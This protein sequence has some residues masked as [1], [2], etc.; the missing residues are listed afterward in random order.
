MSIGGWRLAA[1]GLGTAAMMAGTAG[2]AQGAVRIEKHLALAPG[3][4]LS[5]STEVGSVVVRGDA[6]SGAAV[7]VTSDR[8]DLEQEYE[9]T[10]AATPG[11]AQVIIKRRHP[12]WSWFGGWQHWRGRVEIAVDVPRATAVSV[13]ASGGRVEAS[14]LEGDTELSSSGGAVAAHEL[15]GKLVAHSSGGAV[16]VRDLRGDLHLSSSGGHVRATSVQGAVDAQSSGGS[17]QL[18][19]VAGS[20][21]AD[22]SG[23]RVTVRGAGGRVEASSSGGPV[24]VSFAP[25]NAH[26]GDI[27]S[28]GGGVEVHVDPAVGLDLDAASS[29]GSVSCDL[30]LTVQGKIS[31][32][33]LHGILHGGGEHLHVRSSGGGI[34]I[35]PI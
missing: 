26:G 23:G 19:Q 17:V 3:G 34:R 20:V 11:H 24:E 1:A 12:G 10:F 33:S 16:E 18:E 31:R 15:A 9:M 2:A 35:A 5:V 14:G 7:V 25:G 27:G 30:P 32:H 22:S 6:A 21:R 4:R 13:R 28:S 29:G 8:E